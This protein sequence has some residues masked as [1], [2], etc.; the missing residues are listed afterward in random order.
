MRVLVTG[1]ASFIGGPLVNRLLSGGHEVVGLDNFDD[2]YDA[3]TK[4]RNL[5]AASDHQSFRFVE[6]DIRDP[7]ACTSLA[8]PG[9][10]GLREGGIAGSTG[11]GLRGPFSALMGPPAFQDR[12]GST[13][14][15]DSRAL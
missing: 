6:G 12:R 4:R 13:R 9:G 14:L 2:F 8:R 5:Q 10:H 11:I 7:A 15:V 3:E 1:A